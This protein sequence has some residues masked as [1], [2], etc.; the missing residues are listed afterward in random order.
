MFKKI[1]KKIVDFDLELA[2]IVAGFD[3]NGKA[4]LF[5]IDD[6]KPQRQDL[7]GFCA[8]GSGAVAADY[9]MTYR[10]DLHTKTPLRKAIYYALEGKYF[11]EMAQGVGSRTDM[12]ILKR[13]QATALDED[14][15]IEKKLFPL[16]EKLEPGDIDKKPSVIKTLNELPLKGVPP[17][18]PEKDRKRKAIPKP[19]GTRVGNLRI[20]F[21]IKIG[22]RTKS[23][24]T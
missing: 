13:G 23:K 7:P 2:L 21:P 18:R 16:C 5:C 20:E 24:K 19:K 14:E 1:K 17:I 6:G 12:Y 11:G 4:R 22:K 10:G 9:I 8:I 3:T 15:I